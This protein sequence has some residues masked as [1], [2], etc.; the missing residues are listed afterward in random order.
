MSPPADLRT[1]CVAAAL[2]LGAGCGGEAPDAASATEP[3]RGR[4]TAVVEPAIR[5][6]ESRL[7]EP[8]PAPPESLD[9]LAGEVAELLSV[10]ATSEPEMRA[11]AIEDLVRFGA[12]TEPVLRDALHDEERDAA[13]RIAAAEALGRRDTPYAALVLVELLDR[14]VGPWLKAHAAWA[15]GLGEQ[16]WVVPRLA[17][18]LRYEVDREAWIWLA[19]TLARFHNFAGVVGLQDVAA[20][21]ADA[22]LRALAADALAELCA[23]HGFDDATN[24]NWHWQIANV[25]GRLPPEITSERQKLEIWRFVRDLGDFQL[26]PVD[27]ARFALSNLGEPAAHVLAEALREEEDHVRLH[28]AQTLGRMGPRGHVAGPELVA[29]LDDPVAG[30]EAAQ[31]LGA[32]AYKDAEAELIRRLEPSTGLELRVACAR[33][34]G[35]LRLPSSTDALSRWVEAREPVD[36]RAACATS[37][38]T[39]APPSACRSAVTLLAELM[40][41]AGGIDPAQPER[42]LGAWLARSANAGSAAA[43]EVLESWNALDRGTASGP[44]DPEL[45]RQRRAA[46]AALLAERLDALVD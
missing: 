16:D 26:R 41:G 38:L 46:R 4:L 43:Q 45:E 24:L 14:E 1:A 3:G 22:S 27:D 44:Q 8:E 29:T 40:S 42:A 23:E 7:A 20:N 18:R 39:C 33:A 9:A 32:V 36:L 21:D 11:L 13:E 6:L 17:R 10:A 12:P 28:A 15:L 30:A 35:G 25:D 2:V 34:L 5:A 31:A 19:R 37:L